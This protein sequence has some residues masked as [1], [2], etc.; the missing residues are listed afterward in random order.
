MTGQVSAAAA[1]VTFTA[2]RASV[3]EIRAHLA[4]CDAH[5]I[6]PLSARVD[7]GAYAEKIAN[8]AERFEAWSTGALAGL[9]A[10]YANDPGRSGVFVT[11]VSVVPEL[12]G[13]G[14]GRRLMEN[15]IHHARRT[16]FERL[17]LRVDREQAAAIALYERCGFTR[18]PALERDAAPGQ[19]SDIIMMLEFKEN[20]GRHARL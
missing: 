8:H 13:G 4:R 17:S 11:S 5:F 7:L 16:G 6:P 14:V 9:V 20:D 18:T 2:N 1:P 15:C 10:A 19:R 3:A 12:R